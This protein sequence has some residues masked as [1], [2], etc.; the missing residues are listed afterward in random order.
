MS[1]KKCNCSNKI[2]V[3]SVSEF[4]FEAKQKDILLSAFSTSK[5]YIKNSNQFQPVT[6]DTLQI[7]S[8]WS[9]N[10]FPNY[11][12]PTNFIAQVNG[13]YLIT[14]KI[15]MVNCSTKWAAKLTQNGNEIMG[16]ASITK[17]LEVNGDTTLINLQ[18]G[19]SIALLF[20]SNDSD[21]FIG[22][23]HSTPCAIKEITAKI[24]ITKI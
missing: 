15:C 13:W 20:W 2:V 11:S 1:S 17:T 19:D 18:I 6:F 22:P 7:H 10:T 16:S 5:Q 3:E 24:L 8:G 4:N 12:Y 23:I 21:A 9:V 14:Y